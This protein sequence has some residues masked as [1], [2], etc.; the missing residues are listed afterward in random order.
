MAAVTTPPE[1]K[2]MYRGGMA[3]YALGGSVEDLFADMDNHA[4][5]GSVVN[6]Y[7]AGGAVDYLNLQQ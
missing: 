4:D 5:G 6:G 3:G 2:P 1:P 7:G